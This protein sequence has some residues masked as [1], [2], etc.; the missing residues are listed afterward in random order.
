MI[1]NLLHIMKLLHTLTVRSEFL[2]LQEEI[3]SLEK[4][5]HGMLCAFPNKRRLSAVSGYS[6]ERKFCLLMSLQG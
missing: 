3:Q 2:L 4:I 6:R 5:A 1:L